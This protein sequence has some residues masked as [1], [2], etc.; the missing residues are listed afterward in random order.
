[1]ERHY[2]KSHMRPAAF[3]PP[4]DMRLSVFVVDGMT[5][6]EIHAH[7]LIHAVRPGPPPTPPRA[8]G[9]IAAEA[10][11]NQVSVPSVKLSVYRDDDPPLHA[12]VIGWPSE[13]SEQML[14]AQELA[15]VAAPPCFPAPATTGPSN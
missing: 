3:M 9:K 6:S 12:V 7:G 14:I 2:S 13:K 15:A 1:M 10:I 5:D 8:F 11:L 4:P